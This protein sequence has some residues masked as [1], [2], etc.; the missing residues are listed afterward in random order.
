MYVAHARN[1]L[2]LFTMNLADRKISQKRT[3]S[4]ILNQCKQQTYIE[5]CV[6]SK[7]WMALYLA[8]YSTTD[9]L[10]I[11]VN[12]LLIKALQTTITENT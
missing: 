11:F 1:Y 7:D 4:S 8:Y 5:T 9:I 12:A 3:F 2:F 10:L 6:H